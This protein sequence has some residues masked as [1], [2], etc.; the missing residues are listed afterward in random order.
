MP[1]SPNRPLIRADKR[2]W[3]SA[4]VRALIDWKLR[5]HFHRIHVQGME[6]VRDALDADQS[7]L[8]LLANH[9]C[10]WDFFMAHRLNMAIPADGYG[11][12]DHSNL[13]KFGFFRRIGAYS[14]D[15]GH[16][17]SVRASIDYTAE[18]LRRPR[19]VVW[20]FPQ[21]EIACNAVRPLDFQSGL[22]LLL[23][24]AGT[25]RIVPVALRYEYWQEERPEAFA[26]FGL[27]TLTTSSERFDAVE[28]WRERL[29][30]ELDALSADVLTQDPTRFER[31]LHGR[32]SAHDRYAR[33]RSRFGG[34]DH[35]VST[36][37]GQ[38]KD[39]HGG[40]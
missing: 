30:G 23:R 6:A 7:G 1:T 26:R 37:R 40:S 29:T 28:H 2:G 19:A 10:W 21:G 3:P 31:I 36:S 16:P 18:L 11:M 8:L 38:P 13:L 39:D 22:R 14:V 4:A 9:S 25:L 15:R 33:L 35:R 20:Y 17:A 24:R 12:T 27:A 32:R 34:P 5:N